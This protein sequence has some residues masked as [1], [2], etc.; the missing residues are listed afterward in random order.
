MFRE[1]IRAPLVRRDA[2]PALWQFW[3]DQTHLRIALTQHNESQLAVASPA[4]SFPASYDL[5]VAAHESM[6]ANLGQCLLA[7]TTIEDCTWLELVKL[8]TGEEP[9]VLW[10]HDRSERWSVTLSDEL[11]LVTEFDGD[12]A[13]FKLRF[14]RVTR[15]NTEYDQRVEVAARFVTQMTRDGPALARPQPLTI[16]FAE[17]AVSEQQEVVRSFLDR[18]FSAVFPPQLHFNGLVPPAGGTLAKLNV[19]KLA[20][21]KTAAGWMTLGYQMTAEDSAARLAVD[22]RR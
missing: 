9:R 1:K 22:T 21:F 12:R 16:E 7:G 5:A 3:T 18:K 11:P 4:P 6:I 17:P 2:F 19:L 8:M 15:G 10:V 20:E 13:V 14:K